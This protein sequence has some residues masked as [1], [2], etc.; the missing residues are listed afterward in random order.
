[1]HFHLYPVYRSSISS[2]A[3]IC[4][5]QLNFAIACKLDNFSL[6]SGKSFGCA[7]SALFLRSSPSH[8]LLGIFMWYSNTILMQFWLWSK[9]GFENCMMSNITGSIWSTCPN[10]HAS[11][12]S[13]TCQSFS[14][15]EKTIFYSRSALS[16]QIKKLC[17]AESNFSEEKID[18]G[19]SNVWSSDTCPMTTLYER[20][21]KNAR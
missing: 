15:R 4:T 13:I 20:T 11:C 17:E 12:L 16:K 5:S 1:M 2:D 18:F 10:P 8:D 3:T 7:Q 19:V 9:I 14:R 6:F 21:V